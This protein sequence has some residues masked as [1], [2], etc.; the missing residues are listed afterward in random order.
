MVGKPILVPNMTR[1]PHAPPPVTGGAAARIFG[2]DAFI[3]FALGQ[4]PRGTR[5]YASDL[6]RKLR[7]RG[8]TVFFSEDEA[9]VGDVLDSTLRRA[10]LRSRILV[11][12]ANRGTLAEPRWVRK[13]VE[14][15]RLRHPTRP[16][17][18]VN[19][20][21]ALQDTRLG[22]SAEEW[23]RFRD[24]IWVDEVP[25]A[26]L[27]GEA[28]VE[29][30]T[31][32]VTAPSAVRSATRLR[33]VLAATGFFLAGLAAAALYQRGLAVD[34]AAQARE[35][36]AS[37][38]QQRDTALRGQSLFLAQ[39][40]DQ[41]T[42]AGNAVNGMLL[43]L[44]ALPGTSSAP[45]R[46]YVSQAEA[47]LYDA[48]SQH[49]ELATL[50]G[51]T[52]RVTFAAFSPDGKL[53][54]SASHD[55]SA[56]LWDVDKRAPL[57]VLMLAP[58]EA[59]GAAGGASSPRATS[60]AAG[61]TGRSRVA[62]AAFSPNGTQLATGSLDG[63]VAVWSV[64]DGRLLNR[65]RE[66]SAGV[67]HV[68]YAPDGRRLVTAG[69]DGTVRVWTVGSGT[70]AQ[71][72]DPKSDW[73]VASAE[74]SPDGRYVVAGARGEGAR[75]W[76][77]D[78]GR[79][80]ATLTHPRGLYSA[81]FDP[82]GLTVLTASG[83]GKARLWSVPEGRLVATLEGHTDR[84]FQAAFS[85]DGARILTVSAD[86]SARIWNARTRAPVATLRGHV[87][88]VRHGEF[89]PDGRFVVTASRDDTARLW[90][91]DTGE[92]L[93]TLGGHTH[94]VTHARFSPDGAQ[95]LTT[96]DTTLRLWSRRAGSGVL[97]LRQIGSI[98]QA[99]FSP[100]GQHI[101]T[102]TGEYLAENDH[103]AR[104]WSAAEGNPIAS[105]LHR[106]PLASA[107]FD[108]AGERVVTVD[109][110]G[111][112]RISD[113]RTGLPLVELPKQE[114]P[115]KAAR[116]SPDGKHL[117]TITRDQRHGVQLLDSR[118][119]KLLI[120]LAAEGSDLL[121]GARGDR[122]VTVGRRSTLWEIGKGNDGV[123]E[124]RALKRFA[125]FW[126]VFFSRDGN[127]LANIGP[128]GIT[129]FDAR[130]GD[131]R[132]T[133]G[134]L[135]ELEQEAFSPDGRWL[136]GVVRGESAVRLWDLASTA[137]APRVLEGHADKV[138]WVAFSPDSKRLVSA[139]GGVEFIDG[140]QKWA[141]SD[142]NSARVWDLA[143]GRTV[144]VLKGHSSTV[145]HAE[146]SPDGRRVVTSSVDR[147][148]RVWDIYPNT[149]ALVTRAQQLLPRKLTP[150][151][152]KEFFL[153]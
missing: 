58:A 110:D 143:S 65:A 38:A 48:V 86:H 7:E 150:A 114:R 75:L 25:H 130:T 148:A 51:H 95:I 5:A 43:S 73:A 57:H 103:T 2:Y 40:A 134:S 106:R 89:S 129:L 83:D 127:T 17:I 137:N 140:G 96:G 66:H 36:A 13:E 71:V 108:P 123:P 50:A 26:D 6:A 147:S 72:L 52:G 138:N 1:T 55:G 70:P 69:G 118:T 139:A 41:Q 97:E 63:T 126:A 116:F 102:A 94:D 151:Q 56:R 11:V 37:A 128:A 9:P 20:G 90:R 14:E 44:E 59:A 15:F 21:G 33:V 81:R 85:A 16:V 88:Q 31:R 107:D 42:K 101:L 111:T 10:L 49:R 77:A 91:A 4:P 74:F 135:P 53:L 133:L 60:A 84:V 79:L 122:L 61:E 153:E 80:V 149:Q 117:A 109:I 28:S 39:L 45:D 54:V 78:S 131:A 76:H 132:R 121:Y 112:T 12:V 92:L 18:P 141:T 145:R 47:S 100:D 22:D 30:V 64:A 98:A 34:N 136:A 87:Q 93:A 24:R 152:R 67:F 125:G 62:H 146:F 19:I 82:A 68:A 144:A 115:V 105:I 23:L 124:P 120:S 142:D 99:R 3:S 29:V 32:L 8:F 113:A 27:S 46:P 119:G 35:A 104:V